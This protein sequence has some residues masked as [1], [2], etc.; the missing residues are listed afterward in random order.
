MTIRFGVRAGRSTTP[1]PRD[2]LRE[3]AVLQGQRH[4]MRTGPS[5]EVDT[6]RHNATECASL[7]LMKKSGSW[8][9]AEN[10]DDLGPKN[11]DRV[12]AAKGS[13]QALCLVHKWTEVGRLDLP[14]LRRLADHQLGS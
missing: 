2:I 6:D 11:L 10:P 1:D 13:Y 14:P 7:I 4:P 3:K 8:P 9:V 12:G 5:V